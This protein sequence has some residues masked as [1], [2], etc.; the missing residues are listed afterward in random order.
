MTR[1]RDQQQ[2]DQDTAGSAWTDTG[3]V[4]TTKTGAPLQPSNVNRDFH[5]LLRGARLR[6]IRF[7]DLRHSCAS[8]LLDQ[9][10]D[11]IVI[12]EL[13]V[14]AHIAITADVYAHVR[15]RPPAR[16]HRTHVRCTRRRPGILAVRKRSRPP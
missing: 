9:G 6:K 12:K 1:Q 16:R 14:H 4:F 2:A 10:V 11:L 13:L 3:L 7:H 8:L 5:Q 15:L